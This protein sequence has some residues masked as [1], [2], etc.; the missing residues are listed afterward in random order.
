MENFVLNITYVILSHKILSVLLL[1]V[2]IIVFIKIKNKQPIDIEHC[3]KMKQQ[4][5]DILDEYSSLKTMYPAVAPIVY[6]LATMY[7]KNLKLKEFKSLNNDS[8]R[9]YVY[10]VLYTIPL[11]IIPRFTKDVPGMTANLANLQIAAFSIDCINY[12]YE[13]FSFVPDE[14]IKDLK[15]KV[16]QKYNITDR[17]FI[18]IFVNNKQRNNQ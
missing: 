12:W 9:G 8:T 13:I 15:N 3:Q 5:L 2:F 7:I 11:R 18:D 6:K 10:S 14:K 1:I 4:C 16:I 17:K